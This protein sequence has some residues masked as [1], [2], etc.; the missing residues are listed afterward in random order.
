MLHARTCDRK[1]PLGLG[2]GGAFRSLFSTL[3][4]LV[5]SRPQA[6]AALEG[7]TAGHVRWQSY[8]RRRWREAQVHLSGERVGDPAEPRDGGVTDRIIPMEHDN[9]RQVDAQSDGGGG[10]GV[11]GNHPAPARSCKSSSAGAWSQRLEK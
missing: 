6:W 11:A 10:S 4:P 8:A 1:C 5:P 7:G 9:K 3:R 2:K